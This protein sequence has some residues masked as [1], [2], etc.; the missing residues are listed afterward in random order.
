MSFGCNKILIIGATSGI[1]KTLADKVIQNGSKLIVSGRRQENLDELVQKYG[2]DK[3]SA[4]AF[5]VVQLEQARSQ[6]RRRNSRNR[7]SFT[8]RQDQ[9]TEI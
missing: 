9:L 1:G 5:D 4:K 7:L 6:W 2:S 3:V 8:S